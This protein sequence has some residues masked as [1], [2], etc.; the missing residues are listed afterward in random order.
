MAGALTVDKATS[1]TPG[2]TEDV[3]GAPAKYAPP[4]RQHKTAGPYS[5]VLVISPGQLVVIC[6]QTA[7][8]LDGILVSQDFA[9][10][11]RKTLDN[12]L[13]QLQFAG[14]DMS[15][16][17]KVNVY[18]TDLTNWPVFNE[19]YRDYMPEPRPVR[20][21]IKSGLLNEFQVE[22]EMWAVKP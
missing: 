2:E 12:C 9:E 10:Q 6:G 21:A 22:V 14:C 4:S 17:F 3:S 20:T 11:T 8:D 5:P 18:L 19:I 13:T 7:L 1:H 16:V 15:D